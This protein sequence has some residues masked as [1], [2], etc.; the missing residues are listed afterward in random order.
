MLFFLLCVTLRPLWL[1]SFAFVF[2]R[3]AR[4]IRHGWA[5]SFSLV[6]MIYGYELGMDLQ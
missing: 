1:K 4:V 6:M 2:G 3:E 5:I